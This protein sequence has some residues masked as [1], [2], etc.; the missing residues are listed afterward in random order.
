MVQL[1]ATSNDYTNEEFIRNQ[2]TSWKSSQRRHDMVES[3]EYFA[4]N[5]KIL[6]KARTMSGEN[7]K[8][9]PLPNLPNNI[10]TDNMYGRLVRQK[11]NY[12]VGKPISFKSDNKK[13]EQE[14]TR[15]FDRKFKK[16]LSGIT[17]D[18]WNCGIGWLF[19][20]YDD[21]DKSVKFKRL[22]PVEI[23]PFWADDEHTELEFAIRV[24]ETNIIENNFIKVIERVEVYSPNGVTTYDYTNSSLVNKKSV[25]YANL[26]TA[27]GIIPYTWRNKIPLLAFKSNSSENTLLSRVKCFQDALNHLY[28]IWKDN[29]D[30]DAWTTMLV[31][32]NYE[33]EDF[34]T[35]RNTLRNYGVIPVASVDG[36]E[37]G[38]EKLTLEVNASNYDILLRAM[39]LTI[40]ENGGGYDAKSANSGSD[41]NEMNL[42]SMYVDIDL[43]AD[44]ME[45]EYQSSL[46]DVMDF[47]NSTIPGI[48]DDVKTDLKIIF[49]RDTVVNTAEIM[50]YLIASGVKISNET[51][52][53][54]VPFVDDVKAEMERIGK[55]EEELRKLNDPYAGVFDED[56]HDH[57]VDDETEE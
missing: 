14:L 53:S 4:G 54:Q 20:Y 2:I 12:L 7:G 11:T 17:N 38:V 27:D 16:T 25:G 24:Y 29:M 33:G 19:L 1:D 5:Q 21:I 36:V 47:V 41:P 55:E 34:A 10:L 18:A 43:D 56:E 26:T 30:E 15:T 57:T 49:N 45:T 37:G 32:K 23:I 46:V 22:N 28:S 31:L 50:S 52:L 44:D 3:Q 42:K 39:K 13:Y 8:Q 48:T 51:L 6:T 9:M 40:L 35:F